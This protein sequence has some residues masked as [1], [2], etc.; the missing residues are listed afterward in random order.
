MKLNKFQPVKIPTQRDLFARLGN[1]VPASSLGDNTAVFNM[2]KNEQ[3]DVVTR[4]GNKMT[5]EEYN[6]Y[7][8]RQAEVEMLREQVSKVVSKEESTTE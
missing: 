3:L 2:S 5:D 6:E 8:Q 7:A 1:R 4:I